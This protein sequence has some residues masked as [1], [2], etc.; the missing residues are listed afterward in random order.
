M[1]A[2]LAAA[3]VRIAG[4]SLTRDIQCHML[5]P[6]SQI[7]SCVNQFHSNLTFNRVDVYKSVDTIRKRIFSVLS[8]ISKNSIMSPHV[9]DVDLLPLSIVESQF[10]GLLSTLYLP[11]HFWL[12]LHVVKHLLMGPSFPCCA[13]DQPTINMAP[14]R[15]QTYFQC[16]PSQYNLWAENPQRGHVIV[17]SLMEISSC[18]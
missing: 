4:V 14:Q 11:K 18:M 2:L 3:V 12:E 6:L 8:A 13:R 16:S 9:P 15:S 10:K 5:D 7:I 17:A 1:V